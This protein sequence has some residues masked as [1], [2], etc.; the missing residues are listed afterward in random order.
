MSIKNIEVPDIVEI[1]DKD[2]DLEFHETAKKTMNEDS[3]V[4]EAIYEGYDIDDGAT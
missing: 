4:T 2:I 1:L 3:W